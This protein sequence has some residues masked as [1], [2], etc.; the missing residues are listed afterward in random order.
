MALVALTAL[1][2]PTPNADVALLDP[3]TGSGE[4]TWPELY[5]IGAQK[6]A[7][8]S[9]FL[10]FERHGLICGRK[11][12]GSDFEE[13]EAHF[14]DMEDPT[15]KNI[16][17]Y[18]SRYP[19][20][21][22]SGKYMDATPGY[23]RDL[24]SAERMQ[25]AM[26]EQ[27]ISHEARLI[28]VLREPV[29][30]DLSFFNM[31]KYMWVQA[32]RPRN[33][34]GDMGSIHQLDVCSKHGYDGNFPSYEVS[35]GCQM[36][37]W[38]ECTKKAGCNG[39]CN[40]DENLEGHRHCAL[41][42]GKADSMQ[43]SRLTDGMYFAQLRKYEGVFPRKHIMVI[44]FDG[45]IDRQKEYLSKLMLFSGLGEHHAVNTLPK[46]NTASFKGKI[47]SASC[48]SVSGLHDVFRFWNRALEEKMMDD[49]QHGKAPEHEPSFVSFGKPKCHHGAETEEE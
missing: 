49:H 30:R 41:R 12:V 45:L 39:E 37:Q 43:Y 17:K 8:T 34:D 9:I 11:G 16:K 33:W 14:F 6:S 19:K 28:A 35:I 29:E 22:C 18:K 3:A 46:E 32:G 36:R 7:T 47:S 27:T 48:G 44:S 38:N 24:L 42:N 31:Y 15:E 25:K 26:P 13:K 1:A 23:L 10:L 21:K 2:A 20:H 4:G 40:R 5:L